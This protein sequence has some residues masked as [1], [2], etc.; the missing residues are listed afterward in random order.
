MPSINVGRR[1]AVDAPRPR[2]SALKFM[3]SQAP[4]AASMISCGGGFRGGRS[5]YHLRQVCVFL[6]LFVLNKP[7]V[8]LSAFDGT[9]DKESS[10]LVSSD[11]QELL[12]QQ[13]EALKELSL[14]LNPQ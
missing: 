3:K 5:Q 9:F 14:K 7:E 4:K 1:D 8:F 13:L 6:D 12:V 10:E 11:K 2:R